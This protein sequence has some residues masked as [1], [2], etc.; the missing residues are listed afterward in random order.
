MLIDKDY[1]LLILNEILCIVERQ[2]DGSTHNMIQSYKQNPRGFIEY[3]KVAMTHAPN[4][5]R[6]FMECVHY[7]SSNIMINDY[8]LIRNSPCKFTS[9]FA[10]PFGILLYIYI[11]NTRKRTIFKNDK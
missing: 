1:E 8:Q 10:V 2:T 7:I 5:R 3:R 6:K 9:I 4:Y 11:T